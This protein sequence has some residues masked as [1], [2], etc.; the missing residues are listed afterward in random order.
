MGVRGTVRVWGGSWAE[1]VCLGVK[2]AVRWLMR[3]GW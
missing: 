2:V 3:R 1:S